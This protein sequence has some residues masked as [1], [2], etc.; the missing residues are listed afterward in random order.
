M[1]IR[2]ITYPTS[3]LICIIL[4]GCAT[5]GQAFNFEQYSVFAWICL[6]LV[7]ILTIGAAEYWTDN[8]NK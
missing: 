3:F 6:S 4:L 1:K 5:L 2:L 7:G 8:W